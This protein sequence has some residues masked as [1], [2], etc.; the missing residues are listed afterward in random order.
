MKLRWTKQAIEDLIEARSFIEEHNPKAAAELAKRILRAADRLLQNPNLGRK[1]RLLGTRELVVSKTAYLI[2]Y[3][4][5]QNH[6]EL[7][8][9][10]H[11]RRQYP[12]S[13]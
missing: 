4:V 12:P 6:I 5:H 7:L 2:P 3:R 8:R 13:N 10:F 1:G 9:V 11:G